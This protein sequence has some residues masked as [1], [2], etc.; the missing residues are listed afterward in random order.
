[1]VGY[2]V[3]GGNAFG[4]QQTDGERCNDVERWSEAVADPI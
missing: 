3:G 1:M 2:G 4:A